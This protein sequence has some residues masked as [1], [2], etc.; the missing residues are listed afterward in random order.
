MKTH[1]IGYG[2]SYPHYYTIKGVNGIGT[3]TGA[4]L[5]SNPVQVGDIIMIAKVE[6]TVTELKT[7]KVKSSRHPEPVTAYT[8]TTTYLPPVN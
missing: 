7:D 5:D 4:Y 8:A 6:H 3:I 2:N 1:E